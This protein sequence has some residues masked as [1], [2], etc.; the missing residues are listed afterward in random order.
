MPLVRVREE[1]SARVDAQRRCSCMHET[2]PLLTPRLHLLLLAS[3]IAVA[4][5]LRRSRGRTRRW[6]AAAAS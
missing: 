3:L 6:A 5:P 2:H 1:R 4:A